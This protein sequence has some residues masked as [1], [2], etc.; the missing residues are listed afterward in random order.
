MSDPH[1]EFTV[2]MFGIYRRALQ[3]AHYSANYFREMV[4]ERFGYDT[5]MQL[6]HDSLPAQ[7]YTAL[8]ERGRL[9]LTVEAL[10]LRPEWRD[11]FTDDDRMAAY[12]RLEQ[13]QYQFP[14]DSWHP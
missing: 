3:E 14:N 13:Y 2:A 10:V 12:R 7:G 8:W 5:A 1:P 4:E 9:D 6:I 11:T